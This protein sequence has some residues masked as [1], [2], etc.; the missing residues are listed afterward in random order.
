MYSGFLWMISKLAV[1]DHYKMKRSKY[2]FDT[3]C[4]AGGKDFSLTVWPTLFMF[5][6]VWQLSDDFGIPYTEFKKKY[7]V[8][9][10]WMETDIAVHTWHH[11]TAKGETEWCEKGFPEYRKTL[12]GVLRNRYSPSVMKT[13]EKFHDCHF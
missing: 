12:M 6:W 1:L 7:K 11:R 3:N 8:P 5:R 9:E 2:G 13:M 4:T 10:D